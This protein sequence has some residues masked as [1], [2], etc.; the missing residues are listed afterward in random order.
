MTLSETAVSRAER[1]LE[2][3]I[4]V[5]TRHQFTVQ[6]MA[7]QCRVSRRTMLRDLHALSALGV[8]LAAMPG[9]RGG[10]Q[11][12]APHRTVSL[13]F[14]ADEA[15]GLVLSY[16][17]FVP[18][19]RS[20]F[21][22]PGDAAIRKLRDA[23]PSAVVAELDTLREH[24]AMISVERMYEA[25]LLADLLQAARDGIHLRISYES[26]RAR[27]ERVIYPCGIY[28]GLGFWYCACFDY[29]RGIHVSLR[30]DRIDAIEQVEVHERPPAMTLRQWLERPREREHTLPLRA[31][32]TPRGMA[33]VDW[34]AFGQG[35]TNDAYGV[36][37]IDTPIASGSLEF[38]ARIFLQL[39][40]E[41]TVES[42]PQL[43][44]LLCEQANAILARYAPSGT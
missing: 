5:R 32:I 13:L 35:L 3:L 28:A 23:M 26:R 43:I 6:E 7:D 10:Y 18:Y 14:S 4:K 8:P 20:P 24:V 37:H 39:G 17:A 34:S 30:V 42:P 21:R 22:V 41:A 9:P 12:V 40:G 25:P 15:I 11:L 29:T 36:G 27:S 44:D 33:V 19:A 16:E 1:L 2:L 38:Y 31:T